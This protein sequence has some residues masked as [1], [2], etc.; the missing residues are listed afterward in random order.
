M[1]AFFISWHA[2]ALR[3]KALTLSGW[4][5]NTSSAKFTGGNIVSLIE[6]FLVPKFF[7]KKR[8]LRNTGEG[9]RTA[10]IAYRIG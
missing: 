9:G 10:V 3:Y 8:L 1:P 6:W 7:K 4:R 5:A 2:T